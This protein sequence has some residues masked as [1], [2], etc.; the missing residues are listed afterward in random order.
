MAI[1]DWNKNGKND[2]TDDF[3][4]YQIYKESTKNYS[5]R[6]P[7]SGISNFGAAVAVIGGLFLGAGV[8]ALFGGGENTPVVLTI[9]IWVLCASGLATYF[10][11]INF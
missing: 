11:N 3:I 7:S 8:I 4:E 5:N 10:E 9:I 6:T 1:Y 2:A